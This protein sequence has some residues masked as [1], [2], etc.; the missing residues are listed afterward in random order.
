MRTLRSLL[1]D[2]LVHILL[3]AACIVASMAYQGTEKHDLAFS[4]EEKA[5]RAPFMT[6]DQA[7]QLGSSRPPDHRRFQRPMR[8]VHFD[9]S[10]SIGQ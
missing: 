5:A 1:T 4:P 10:S 7:T 9:E 2:P 6:Q 3:V 8:P